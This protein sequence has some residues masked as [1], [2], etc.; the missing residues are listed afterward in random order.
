MKSSAK[1]VR[2]GLVG[3]GWG[4]RVAFAIRDVPDATL[5]ACHARTPGARE[6]FA[7]R[8]GVGACA[9]FGGMIADDSLDGIIIMTPNG[10][11]GELAMAAMRAGRHVLVTK[12]IATTLADAAAMIRTARETGRVLAVGHQSRRHPA[13]RALKRLIDDGQLGTVKMIEGNTSSPTGLN[14][15]PADWRAQAAECPGGPLIQLGIHYVDNFQHFFGPVRTVSAWLGKT[16]CG[17]VEPDTATL[18]LNFASGTAGYLGSSYVTAKARWIRVSGETG[19]AL[20]RDDGGLQLLRPSGET[21]LSPPV[22]DFDTVLRQ[23]LAEEVADFVACLRTGK[24]PEIS[25]AAAARNLA[26]VL[27]A[28]ES[29]RR[30]R[31]VAVEELLRAAGL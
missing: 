25:G 1:K 6:A 13:M 2:L 16:G 24:E 28:V 8:H 29:H 5:A 9:T 7:A 21:M 14:V 20:F 19:S 15:V 12:P 31:P 17:A 27:A 30:A 10:T 23:M 26:V 3:L 18:C 4:D 11:H 22:A